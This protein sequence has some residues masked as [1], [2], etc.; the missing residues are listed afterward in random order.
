MKFIKDT[1]IGKFLE[2]P[3]RFIAYVDLDGKKVKCHVPNTGRI[4][5][6]LVPGAEVVLRV[7]D[8][9]NRKTK[10]SLIAGYKEG[11]LINIDSQIPN[12][13]IGEALEKGLI[14][15]LKEY[16]KISS[17]KTYNSSRF[18]FLLENDKGDK[19]FLEVKGVTLEHD[20]ISSFPD[21][22][23][24]RGRK[25]IKELIDAKAEGYG[26]GV[27]FLIQME[28]MKAFTPATDKDPK[29]TEVL[30]KAYRKGVDIFA[31]DTFVTERSLDINKSIEVI[32]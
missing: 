4:K 3:N 17:E 24:E 18:D 1:V 15:E 6:I 25:H 8:N 9:P 30:K 28:N 7:E 13:V 32:L 5:E 21:A 22:P 27:M 10:F 12:K 2:R 26:A 16:N 23:T 31:Y 11:R 14:K 20:F 29:F 19:Y